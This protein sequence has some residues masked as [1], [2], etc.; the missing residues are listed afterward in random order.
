MGILA[1][2]DRATREHRIVYYAA[3][4]NVEHFSEVMLEAQQ[5]YTY[6]GMARIIGC[7]RTTVN[8]LLAL[9]RGKSNK[10]S[11]DNVARVKVAKSPQ[12]QKSLLEMLLD[13]GNITQAEIDALAAPATASTPSCDHVS[14][15]EAAAEIHRLIHASGGHLSQANIGRIW[16]YSPAWLGQVLARG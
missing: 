14:P 8:R 13:S 5:F 4:P 16:G 6:D 12:V 2:M 3:R 7:S 11:N 1:N 15:A 9:A 10:A